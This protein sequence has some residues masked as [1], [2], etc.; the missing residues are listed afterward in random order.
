M[1]YTY[2]NATINFDGSRWV[3]KWDGG[4]ATAATS[5]RIEAFIDRN[6]PP[7]PSAGTSIYADINGQQ[8]KLA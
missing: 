6:L 7:A 4:F 3:A 8:V 5:E 2:K 1:S